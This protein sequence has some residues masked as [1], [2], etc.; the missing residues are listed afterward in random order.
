MKCYQEIEIQRHCKNQKNF[1]KNLEKKY[2]KFFEV[3]RDHIEYQL[4]QGNTLDI[5]LEAGYILH[6][7]NDEDFYYVCFIALNEQQAITD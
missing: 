2:P 3:W 4:N 7:I 1:M 5:S 6:T